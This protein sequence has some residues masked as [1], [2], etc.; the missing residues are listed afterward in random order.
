MSEKYGE[1]NI[2]ITGWMQIYIYIYI[3]EYIYI[4][5]IYII[6]VDCIVLG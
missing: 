2:Y 4:Y 5:V 3:N 6:S 1:K